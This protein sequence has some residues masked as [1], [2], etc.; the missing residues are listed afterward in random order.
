M[1]TVNT[2]S[3]SQITEMAKVSIK[4][5]PIVQCLLNKHYSYNAL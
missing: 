1:H 5:F 2:L 3:V 4:Q